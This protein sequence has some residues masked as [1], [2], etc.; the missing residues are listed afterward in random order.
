MNKDQKYFIIQF[1][2]STI[3]ILSVIMLI[4]AYYNEKVNIQYEKGYVDACKDFYQ[5][6]LKYELIENN[7]GTKEWRKINEQK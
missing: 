6:K 7:N 1:V 3:S 2:L 5:G 4:I